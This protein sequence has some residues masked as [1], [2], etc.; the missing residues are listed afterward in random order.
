MQRD[1]WG[2]L[3]EESEDQ[4]E[5][6]L[7]RYDADSFP[8][9]LRR[10]R[11]ISE[12]MTSRNGYLL[13]SEESLYLF[14]DA[15]NCFIFGHFAACILV[16]QELLEHQLSSLY[17]FAGN[18]KLAKAGFQ[19]LI[20]HTLADKVLP[21][22]VV[23]KLEDLRQKRN[24]LV[25]FTDYFQRDPKKSLVL[26]SVEMNTTPDRILEQQAKDAILVTFEIFNRSPFGLS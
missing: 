13:Y 21:E 14:E 6:E 15:K 5:R 23:N 4:W 10:L 22:F 17:T 25:H 9:R 16:C 12:I 8:D 26:Q 20:E 1:F 18:R 7:K 2:K 3:K 19:K 24:P 11:L